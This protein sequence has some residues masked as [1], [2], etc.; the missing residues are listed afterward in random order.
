MLDC[1]RA[2][3]TLLRRISGTVEVTFPIIDLVFRRG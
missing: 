3:L 2:V 1:Y